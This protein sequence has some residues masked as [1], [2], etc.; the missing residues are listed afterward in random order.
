[1]E[2][3]AMGA[4]IA[5]LRK[6]NGMT[7]KELAERLNVSDKSVSRWE[8]GDG[9]P[10]LA[11][12]PVLAEVFGVTCDELLRGERR[13]PDAAPAGPDPKAEKQR[14]RLIDS[15]L[16]R[17]RNQ[18][19]SAASFAVAGVCFAVGIDLGALEAAIALCVG[20]V[21]LLLAALVEALAVSNAFLAVAGEEG[22]QTA[23]LRGTVVRWAGRVFTFIVALLAFLAPLALA[24]SEGLVLS[25]WLVYGIPA[26]VAAGVLCSV[27]RRFLDVRFLDTGVLTPPEREAAAIRHNARL[28]RRCLLGLAAG[29]AALFAAHCV[30]TAGFSASR[31]APVTTF[32]DW[33]SFAAYME[34]ETPAG[35]SAPDSASMRAEPAGTPKPDREIWLDGQGNT[36]SRDEAM[37]YGTFEITAGDG[38]VVCRFV[39]RNLAAAS[40]GYSSQNGVP[41]PPIWA[42]TE[43]AYREG[44]RLLRR[45]NGIFAGLYLAAVAVCAAVYLFNKKRAAARAV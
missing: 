23:C 2:Q 31:L 39:K 24:G 34:T 21:I 14:Q 18:S 12:I 1:M 17:F 9:A 26:E 44:A 4:F 27:V 5:A 8:R 6:A 7:Q 28:L 13:P 33:D 22:A 15:T 38:S 19:I 10:D 30:V 11:L 20:A 42:R 32:A 43:S 36:V 41:V 40:W 16:T 29:C 45:Y 35:G 25:S 3:K 37:G